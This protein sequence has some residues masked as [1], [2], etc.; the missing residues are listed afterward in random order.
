MD[1]IQDSITVG[2]T[3]IN[4]HKLNWLTTNMIVAFTFL[5]IE[6]AISST[7]REAEINSESKMWKGAMMKE[8]NSLHKNNTWELRELSKRK[9]AIGCK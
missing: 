9:K 5:I 2:R 4:P 6:E 3:R 7:Y 8:I 1:D